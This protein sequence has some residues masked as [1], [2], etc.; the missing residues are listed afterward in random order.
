[1]NDY[2]NIGRGAAD[3][4]NKRLRAKADLWGMTG[5]I[6]ADGVVSYAGDSGYNDALGTN[7]AYVRLYNDATQTK[8]ARAAASIAARANVPV[9]VVERSGSYEITGID[10]ERADEMYGDQVAAVA[11]PPVRFDAVPDVLIAGIN[12]LEGRLRAVSG[13]QVTVER[14]VY[15]D[16]SGDTQIWDSENSG[17]LTLTPP[18]QVSS[19]DQLAYVLISLNPDASSPALE[20]DAGTSVA[21]TLD[22]YLSDAVDVLALLPAGNVPLWILKL[23]TGDT[24]LPTPLIDGNW[25]GVRPFV[26]GG[27]SSS[28][29]SGT[30]TSVGLSAPSLL[31]VSSSPVTTS[32]TIALTLATQTANTAFLGPS[33]GSPAAPT[34]RAM[35]VA[36]LPTVDIAHGGTGSTS[37]SAARTALGL[38]TMATQNATAIAV[39]GGSITGITDLTIADGGTGASTASAARTNLGLGTIATQDA[40]TVAITGGSITGITD[41]AL[42]DGGTGAST[43]SAARTNLGLGTMA[44]QDAT[45]VAITGGTLNGATIGATTP[46]TGA[47]T[48]L[49]ASTGITAALGTLATIPSAPL[50]MSATYTGT[51]SEIPTIMSLG[52][53]D[54]RGTSNLSNQVFRLTYSRSATATANPSAFDAALCLVSVFNASQTSPFAG[55]NIGGPIVASGKTVSDARGIWINDSS[56]AGAVTT[57]Y[58]LLI[59]ALTKAT[60]NYAIYTNAGIVR[61]GGDLAHAGSNLGFYGVTAAARPA[62]YT[63]TYATPSRTHAARTASTL[64]VSVGTGSTT[65]AN[66]GASF[67]QTTLNNIVRSLADQINN[68]KADLDNTAQVVNSI[69][70]DDQTLGLKQ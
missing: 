19:V 6:E 68:L 61:L 40:S 37:A 42:A 35:V 63:Q 26:E 56:G 48:T 65:I 54:N 15:V 39:T 58:G 17:T 57:Q 20:Q 12:V 22:L 38:G 2:R 51:A 3:K 8:V 14:F 31:T 21:A 67:N 30:V 23:T 66:V 47:F 62:A 18:A 45:A 16:S 64:S 13:L 60:T 10:Q 24:A 27:I 7:Q 52:F 50:A 46:A 1:M 69:I 32:G 9:K 11:Q 29:A 53:T 43:A 34:F 25:I 41:L 5:K 36:D 28:S 70:D 33:T 4:A 49:S 59:D 55:L 44:T